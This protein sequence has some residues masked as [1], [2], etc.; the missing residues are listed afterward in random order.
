MSFH[1]VFEILQSDLL[2]ENFY[3]GILFLWRG[4]SD[5]TARLKGK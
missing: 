1:H 3:D 2:Q 5:M 4:D